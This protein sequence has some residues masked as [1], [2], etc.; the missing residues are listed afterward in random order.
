M[1]RRRERLT[2]GWVFH[3]GELGAIPARGTSKAGG[4][5]G[6]TD[7][8]YAELT[9]DVA[10]QERADLE[11]MKKM[12]PGIDVVV[13]ESPRADDLGDGWAEVTLPHDFVIE[14]APTPD[15]SIFRG[16]RPGG[17]GYYR[18]RFAL[19]DEDRRYV[20]EFDGVMRDSTVWCNGFLVG[21]HLSGYAS[22]RYDITELLRF[23]DE[24]ENVILVRCD[25]TNG[26]GWW[27]E[28]GGIY[29][30]VWLTSFG[31]VHVDL[32]GIFV[33]TPDV[34]PERATV[35]LETT[36][37]N[38]TND[39]TDLRIATAILAPDRAIIGSDEAAATVHPDAETTL[40]SELVVEHPELWNID[41]PNLYTAVTELLLD[42]QV[43]D[44]VET[45]FGI[46]TI[47]FRG[48][49]GLFVNGEPIWVRGADLH[50]DF[51]GL[52][53]ALPDRVI[54]RKLELIKD[55]G[56]NAV[57]SAHHPSSPALLDTADR[58][59]MLVIAENRMLS[60]APPFLDDLTSLIKRGRNHPSVFMWSLENEESLQGTDHGDRLLE[61]LMRMVRRFDPTRPITVGGVHNHDH[62]YYDRLDVVSMHYLSLRRSIDEVM[63]LRPDRP[64]IATE[65]GLF[66]T[67]RGQYDDD[68]E[69]GRASAFGTVMG[70]FGYMTKDQDASYD[71]AAT[72]QWFADHRE[73]G[74]FV[75][76]GIDYFGEP[77][78][79]RWPV[80]VSSYGAI[81]ICGFPKDHAYLLRS[82][83]R[84]EP[85]VHVLPHWTWP[86]RDGQPIRTWVYTN[87]DEVEL[88][89]NGR[90]ID[91]RKPE[92]NVVR[93]DDGIGYEPGVLVA[94]G[95]RSGELV[96]EHRQ[97]T[98]GEP[99]QLRLTSG[100]S[101]IAAG[102]ADVALVRVEVL[103]DEGRL[104][105]W[106]DDEV[107]FTV[108]GPGVIAGV[109]NGD[110]VSLE[111][112]KAPRR[113]VFRGLCLA[114]VR[115][116]KNEGTVTVHATAEGL[117]PAST[118]FRVGEE[119]R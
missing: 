57:R 44:R 32:D 65:D 42:D 95:Y 25:T 119:N 3:R 84:D 11:Q 23:G 97:E 9:D 27:Y 92:S 108:D 83:F 109:G 87:C 91:R 86:G 41:A 90:I 79:M 75:W 107:R 39:R 49:R 98:V 71:H 60:S 8:T 113:R 46:R 2:D 104:Q 36:L 18:R 40:T 58:I 61:R 111:S 45:T 14:Q 94:R 31:G 12:L 112:D 102:G 63:A 15:G 56:C 16:F 52:G 35:K 85:L 13:R 26:E 1:I 6:I 29:R 20:V 105:P 88:E 5:G 89:C 100:Q 10:A 81:D 4:C 117:R 7:L 55:M 69:N 50:Q 93:L 96:A 78:P 114:I 33:T 68:T 76:T 38:D 17:I 62:A 43:I 115:S 22:F 37:R 28:G 24:G 21:D 101:S 47:E 66:P 54:A 72:W 30:D 77:T 48:D 103:D 53:I 116:A 19:T 64:H 59:G 118:T 110:P 51:A 82:F 70:L 34:S 67:V 74:G 73:V 106:A 80:V 99:A